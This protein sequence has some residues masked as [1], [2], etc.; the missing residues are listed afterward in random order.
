MALKAGATLCGEGGVDADLTHPA[1]AFPAVPIAG[2]GAVAVG[3]TPANA[4]DYLPGETIAFT[5][6][7]PEAVTVTGAPTIAL[8]VG[9]RSRT[10]IH[11]ADADDA[12]ATTLV[13]PAWWWRTMS[14]AT[15]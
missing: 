11:N 13:L 7:F 15:G 2:S 3:S 5:A 4:T 10:L 12:S 1:Y 14:S 9:D 8:Q 6:P